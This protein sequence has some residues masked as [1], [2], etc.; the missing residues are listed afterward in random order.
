MVEPGQPVAERAQRGGA[1][2]DQPFDVAVLLLQV[3]RLQEQ[4]LA[5][6]DLVLPTHRHGP[7]LL[8]GAIVTAM[9]VLPAATLTLLVWCAGIGRVPRQVAFW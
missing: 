6:D 7:G 4:A 5:P 3:L 8:A 9:P 2:A 1:A